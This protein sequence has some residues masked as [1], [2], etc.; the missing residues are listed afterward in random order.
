MLRTVSRP[1]VSTARW[2]AAASPAALVAAFAGF[3]LAAPAAA[4]EAPTLAD[5]AIDW[6]RG[7]YATPVICE[8]DG[9]PV[10][11]IRRILI[12]PGPPRQRPAVAKIVFV[13]LDAGEAS[14]CFTE[15]KADTPNL[16]GSVQIRLE[17]TWRP[18][19]AERDFRDQLRRKQGFEYQ[20]A[21]GG[22]RIQRVQQ[23]RAEARAVDFQ[24]GSAVLRTLDPASDLGR[25]VAGFDSPRKLLLELSATDGTK[26]AFPLYMTD[27][28]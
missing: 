23:P 8:F 10:R 12:A 14:R 26:L 28:R 21:A 4:Q 5:M 18:D 11:G 22:L 25:L 7:R 17:G 20:I 16:T 3:L 1:V 2:F 13:D 6:A 19:T 9:K 27:A 24:G 15:L